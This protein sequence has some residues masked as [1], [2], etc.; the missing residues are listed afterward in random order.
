MF[1]ARAGDTIEE[2]GAARASRTHRSTTMTNTTGAQARKVVANISLS[3]DGRVHGRGGEHDM[4]WIAPHAVSD[5]PR[6]LMVRMAGSATTA[7]LGRKNYE[8]FG[9][10][11]PAVA[12]DESAEPRDREMAQW[13]DEVEK[14]VFSS[15]LTDATWKNSRI[16]NGDVA[17]EVRR[18]RAEPGGDIVV[19]NSVSVIKA[20]LEAGEVDRLTLTLCPE[21]VGGGA[22]LF[23][24]GVPETSWTLTD[25]STSGTGAICLT[26]DRKPAGN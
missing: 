5:A 18:L 8:G 13:L 24:D 21:L 2:D 9:G 16:V 25:L 12:R 7:L 17:A 11:W 15:T 19:L 6:D 4:G 10:F 20:L 1:P 23:E 22:R 3:L 26:Y 14:V